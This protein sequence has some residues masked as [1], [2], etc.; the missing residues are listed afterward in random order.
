MNFLEGGEEGYYEAKRGVTMGLL[1]KST[2]AS[3]ETKT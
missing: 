2:D 1:N 3:D